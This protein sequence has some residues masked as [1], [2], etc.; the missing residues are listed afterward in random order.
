MSDEHDW[1]AFEKLRDGRNII[2]IPIFGFQVLSYIGEDG[3]PGVD[4][5]AV[6]EQVTG[7]QALGVIMGAA[8]EMQHDHFHEHMDE[9]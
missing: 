7:S 3:K 9:Q 6:G 1:E 5:A 2:P 8:M 4:F